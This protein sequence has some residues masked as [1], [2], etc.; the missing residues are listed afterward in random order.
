MRGI[1]QEF[2][3]VARVDGALGLRD[4]VDAADPIGLC[5]SPGERQHNPKVRMRAYR[6]ISKAHAFN[7]RV[8]SNPTG[9]KFVHSFDNTRSHAGVEIQP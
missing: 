7:S 8:E 3:R 1:F 6:T 2:Q 4:P 5:R 9:F